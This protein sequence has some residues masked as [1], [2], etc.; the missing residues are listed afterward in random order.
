MS[1]TELERAEQDARDRA[2]FEAHGKLGPYFRALIHVNPM[3]V[4]RAT[5]VFSRNDSG[6]IVD[7]DWDLKTIRFHDSSKYRFCHRH[8]VEGLSW[9]DAGVD[10]HFLKRIAEGNI[11]DRLHTLDE[12]RARY[13]ALDALYESF[14]S[15]A[16]FKPVNSRRDWRGIRYRDGIYIHV[17]REGKPVFGCAGYHRLAI[18]QILGMERIPAQLGVVHALALASGSWKGFDL[19]EAGGEARSQASGG[20]EDDAAG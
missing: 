2:N 20:T 4:L 19:T 12:V 9:K 10:T 16:P 6:R 13:A 18:A 3:E 14:R 8:F 7:G 5:S 11:V 17:N 15:G 1:P